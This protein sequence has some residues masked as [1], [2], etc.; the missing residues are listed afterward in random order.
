M[1]RLKSHGKRGPKNVSSREQEAIADRNKALWSIVAQVHKKRSIE[2]VEAD[3]E[4][5]ARRYL[6]IGRLFALPEV[7]SEVIRRRAKYFAASTLFLMR[8][9][10]VPSGQALPQFIAGVLGPRFL[11][12]LNKIC[13]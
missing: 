12:S 3:G 5:N 11:K 10:D 13:K 8:E 2:P 1:N 9:H 7:E 4:L 6:E